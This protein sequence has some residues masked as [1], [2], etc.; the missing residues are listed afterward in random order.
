MSSRTCEISMLTIAKKLLLCQRSVNKTRGGEGETVAD[1][2]DSP[3]K[4]KFRLISLQLVNTIFCRKLRKNL[5]DMELLT[6]A[7]ELPDKADVGPEERSP[8]VALKEVSEDP[9]PRVS[10]REVSEDPSPRVTF[11]EVYEDN[12]RK[13]KV[14]ITFEEE[15]EANRP[16]S[17][18]RVTLRREAS[19]QREADQEEMRFVA[20]E[21]RRTRTRSLINYRRRLSTK[22]ARSGGERRHHSVKTREGRRQSESHRGSCPDLLAGGGLGE[23]GK[24]SRPTGSKWDSVDDFTS[25]LFRDNNNLVSTQ[26]D[27]LS[28]CFE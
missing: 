9:S 13:S 18:E 3:E 25:L 22:A 11:R 19:D 20:R 16:R 21:G 24:G 23:N 6:R 8:H 10:F 15:Q 4:I 26:E 5:G 14:S 27:L 2:P 1:Q 17:V 28:I 12:C 7:E